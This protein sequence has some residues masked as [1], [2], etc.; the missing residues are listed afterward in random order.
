MTLNNH[1]ENIIVFKAHNMEEALQKADQAFRRNGILGTVWLSDDAGY[2]YA[3]DIPLRQTNNTLLA[4]EKGKDISAS[5]M[6]ATG[7]VIIRLGC[8]DE[9]TLAH[10][11]DTRQQILKHTSPERLSNMRKLTSHFNLVRLHIRYENQTAFHPHYDSENAPKKPP[12]HDKL[13]KGRRL[14]ILCS[15]SGPGTWIYDMKEPRVSSMFNLFSKKPLPEP[16]E[17]PVG[18]YVFLGGDDWGREN[19]LFHSS[20]KF[21]SSSPNVPRVLDVYDCFPRNE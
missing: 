19:A 1:P 7:D 11:S 21:K 20:P 5:P 2:K 4:L 9:F 16:W 17:A 15:R 3:N 12:Q 18:S 10:K 13:F 6:S 8:A 14:R